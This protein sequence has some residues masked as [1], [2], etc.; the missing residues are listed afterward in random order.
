MGELFDYKKFSILFV[1]DEEKARQYFTLA[2]K[3]DFNIMTASCVDDALE[4]IEKDS[5]SIGIVISDQRMPE[6]QGVD[7]LKIVRQSNPNIIRILT[8][9]YS[10]I[11][12][13][14]DSVNDGAI[15]KYIKKPWDI[16]ELRM[17]M[18]R[19]MEYFLIKKERDGLVKLKISALARIIISDR[20]RSYASMAAC[21]SH[22]FNNSMLALTM[23]LD[24]L[25]DKTESF[26]SD[27]VNGLNS[28]GIWDESWSLVKKE[29]NY[30]IKLIKKF[31]QAVLQDITPTNK[32]A[33]IHA[34]ITQ[35][36]QDA[37]KEYGNHNLTLLYNNSTP[38]PIVCEEDLISKMFNNILSGLQYLCHPGDS[39]EVDVNPIDDIHETR[40]IMITFTSSGDTWSNKSILSLFAPFSFKID[41]DVGIS[42]NLLSS[43]F[44]TYHHYG[45]ISVKRGVDESP[46]IEIKFPLNPEKTA[47]WS[48]EDN[49][50][51]KILLHIGK[52]E[53]GL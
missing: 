48:T 28:E 42:I 12:R 37:S 5:A 24:Q 35:A 49:S 52:W 45:E 39:I 16:D 27:N 41:N 20:I 4:R 19:A 25:P 22:R 31:E 29:C 17:I 10:D 15:Y 9:A 21:F 30:H 51:D 36:I 14:I 33:D 1:D 18:K 34:L 3:K 38:Y 43:F 53:Q 23:F 6:K 50:M 46:K 7:L 26:F 13:A 11:E 8:T 32:S 40:S 2:L 47:S 44:I